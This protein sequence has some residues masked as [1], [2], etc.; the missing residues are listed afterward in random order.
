MAIKGISVTLY[1]KVKTG[2]DAFGAPIYIEKPVKVENILVSPAQ[3]SDLPESLN[4]NGKKAVYILGVP[5]GDSHEWEDRRVNFF[6]Q[7][8]KTFGFTTEG[9]EELIPLEWNKKVQVERYE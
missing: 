5:K 7:D 9:I 4:I 2:T 6:G 8:W 1:E 3:S